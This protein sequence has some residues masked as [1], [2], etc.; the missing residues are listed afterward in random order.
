MVISAC[1]VCWCFYIFSMIYF[2][3]PQASSSTG[4]NAYMLLYR[5]YDQENNLSS[6]NLLQIPHL[7]SFQLPPAIQSI[8][9]TESASRKLRR[10]KQL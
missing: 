6:T 4:C 5:R 8:V 2:I 1:V 3:Y 10:E 9:S 7:E